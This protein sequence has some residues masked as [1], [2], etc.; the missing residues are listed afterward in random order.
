M[1]EWAL[2][3]AVLKT[4][5]E[6]A[7]KEQIIKI[8]KITVQLG[9]MQ[10]INEEIFRFILNELVEMYRKDFHNVKIDLIMEKTMLQCNHCAHAWPFGSSKHALDSDESESIHFIPEV[11]LVHTRCPQCGRPDFRITKGRGVTIASI[12][13]VKE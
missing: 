11:A 4:A 13:G 8:T 6:V 12:E 7:H 10:Q 2:A 3:E 9:E 1:H 5:I